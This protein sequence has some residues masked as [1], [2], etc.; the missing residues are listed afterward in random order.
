MN[1]AIA[2]FRRGLV[3]LTVLLAP[4]RRHVRRFRLYDP[5]LH[6]YLMYLNRR[7]DELAIARSLA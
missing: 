5:A 4:I 6:M 3:P 1:R 2:D 7:R